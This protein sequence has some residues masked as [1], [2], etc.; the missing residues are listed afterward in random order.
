MVLG[1]MNPR[2]LVAHSVLMTSLNL[3][4]LLFLLVSFGD[5]RFVSAPSIIMQINSVETS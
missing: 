2:E 5:I 1:V 4:T 3:R